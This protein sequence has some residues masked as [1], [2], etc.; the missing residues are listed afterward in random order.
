M[1][2]LYVHIPFC[3][4]RCIYCGFYS[5]TLS[6]LTG[7]YIEAVCTELKNTSRDSWHKILLE[8]IETVYIGGGTPS[9]LSPTLLMKLF[10][11]IEDSCGTLSTLEVTME[12]NPDDLTPL[13]TET[14]AQLPVNR[15]SMGAQTFADE[16]LRF[17]HRRHN[18]QQ[19]SEAVKWLR[20]IGIGNIS[21]D[22]MFGFPGETLEEWQAD[23]DKALELHVE[24]ISAY[25][26]MFEEGTP[27]HRMLSQGEVK[28]TDE[29]LSLKMYETLI[30]QLSA[31]GYEHY[32][33]SNFARPGFHSRHNS[34]YWDG[35]PYIG[36]GAAAHSYD[37]DSR[38][39]NISDVREYIQR[40]KSGESPIE[41]REV[42]NKPA[43]FDDAVMTALRTR[44]GLSIGHVE[45]KFG[46]EMKDYLMANAAPHLEAK[47]LTID[48]N[49]YLR[50][51]RQGLFVSDSVM[52]DLMYV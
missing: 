38:W 32:E 24:H 20:D 16:R 28:E 42:L 29:E 36:L 33:I 25:S 49:G 21:I 3:K 47:R 11:A 10:N 1:A 7:E 8:N 13:Y 45:K 43:R 51:T 52:A 41:E 23:I 18:S 48:D 30:D 34:S 9:Q 44:R 6:Q 2:G 22:L 40:M 14:L 39:W 26:L 35:T 46:R 17:L 37:I 31:A 15:I 4:S 27:L 12:C 50:L 5:T 19:V